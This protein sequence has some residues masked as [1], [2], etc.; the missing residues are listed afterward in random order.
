MNAMGRYL[1]AYP[2]GSEHLKFVEVGD[3]GKTKIYDVI[4]RHSGF[5]IATVKWHG[6][7]R[8]YCLFPESDTLFDEGCLK[9]ISGFLRNLMDARKKVRL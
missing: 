7:W 6:G 9:Q 2:P 3:T 8:K 5:R 1:D 4:N